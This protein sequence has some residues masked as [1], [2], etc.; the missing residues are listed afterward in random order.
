M[1]WSDLFL[2]LIFLTCVDKKNEM[3]LLKNKNN[4]HT[5]MILP[6]SL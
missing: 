5:K 6:N 1:A 4:G 3:P 2:F